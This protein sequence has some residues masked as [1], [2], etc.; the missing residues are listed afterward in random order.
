MKS[1]ALTLSL[2]L[3]LCA[4]SPPEQAPLIKD[5]NAVVDW[6]TVLLE[7]LPHLKHERGKRW[8]LILWEGPGFT[9]LP[10]STL[11]ALL[12]RGIVPHLRPETSMIES[13]LA[14]QAAGGPVILMVGKS[15]SWGY[16][17]P[18]VVAPAD[19]SA[20]KTAGNNMRDTLI[21]FRDAGV[22]INAVWL[23]YEVNPL[24]LNCL[25]IKL[26]NYNSYY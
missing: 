6:L 20:W 2:M 12:S 24:N 18:K 3:S 1:I 11:K 25:I 22:I 23:D 15:G 14:I 17:Y 13:S 4:A 9:P 8:P 26:Y 16:G 7:R 10:E 19:I 5:R 21:S